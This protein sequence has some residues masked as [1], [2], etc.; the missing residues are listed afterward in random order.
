MGVPPGRLTV[1]DVLREESLRLRLVAGSAGVDNEVR[2]I[3]I[4]E[5]PDPTRWLAPGDLLLTT[6]LALHDD[7]EGQADLVRRLAGAGSAGLGVAV[8]IY[9]H[10][11]SPEM[12]AEADRVGL[13][14][15]EV[16]YEIPFRTIT[17]LVFNSLHSASFYQLRRSLSVQDRLLALLLEDRGLDHLTSSV[18]ML[19]STSVIVFDSIGTVLAQANARTKVTPQLRDVVWRTYRDRGGGATEKGRRVE[20]DGHVLMLEEVR[21]GG[22]VEQVVC[23]VYPRGENV[24]EMG[25]VVVEYVR[26]LLTLELHRSRDEILLKKRMRAG[27][28]DDLLSGLGKPEDL[29]ERLTHFGFEP[30]RVWTLLVCDIDH[31]SSVVGSGRSLAQEESI[32]RLKADF[33]EQVDGYFSDLRRP[34]LSQTKSDSVVV[35]VQLLDDGEEALR[36][37]GRQLRHRLAD[38]FP[39]LSVTV[40]FGDGYRTAEAVPRAYTQA[41]EAT[42]ARLGSGEETHVRL[43]SD[44]GPR[45]RALENQSRERLEYFAEMTLGPLLRYDEDRGEHLL[46]TLRVFLEADRTVTR[47]ASVLYVHPNTLRNRL[48]KVEELLGVSLEATDVLV[49]IALGFQALRILDRLVAAPR[50]VVRPRVGADRVGLKVD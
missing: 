50:V 13:P 26:K 10:R 44:L 22:R 12:R 4:S 5:M 8:D 49:D 34:Y 31:F 38:H 42:D 32:Q 24:S 46:E 48:H 29:E 17:S 15:F 6:E 39:E 40:G 37:L 27:L 20:T 19:L 11:T 14:L 3:H 35:L 45:I 30:G 47:A 7:L 2:G 1:A 28:L 21:L 9:L 41:R 33:K 36:G 16:P 25:R 18:A 23:F 43:F